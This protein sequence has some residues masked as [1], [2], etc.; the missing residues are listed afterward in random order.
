MEQASP[1]KRGAQ[2]REK[3]GVVKGV[4]RD[5][6]YAHPEGVTRSKIRVVASV[7][8]K[9]AIK[10]GSLKQGIRLLH[11][12][13]EIENRDGKWFPTKNDGQHG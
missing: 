12:A 11:K 9:L 3:K 6:I 2:N 7:E 13:K 4:I 8:K 10:E 1:Q 5:I